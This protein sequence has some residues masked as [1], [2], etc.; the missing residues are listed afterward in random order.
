MSELRSSNNGSMTVP[1][2]SILHRL[3]RAAPDAGTPGR[4][5]PFL[6]LLIVGVAIWITVSILPEG[7]ERALRDALPFAA[8]S[9]IGFWRGREAPVFAFDGALFPEQCGKASI[10]DTRTVLLDIYADGG[11]PTALVG[12]PVLRLYR[13]S[14]QLLWA[15]I[16]EVERESLGVRSRLLVD[17]LGTSLAGTLRT[18]YF[19]REYRGEVTEILRSALR[20]AWAA[21]AV[22]AA[23]GE[24]M[25]SVDPQIVDGL[26]DGILPVA[27]EKAERTLWE[28]LRSMTGALFSQ[29]SDTTEGSP[30]ARAVRAIFEDERVQAHLLKTLPE[31]ASD[32]AISILATRITSEI[33]LA[34]INDARVPVLMTTLLTDPQMIRPELGAGVDGKFLTHEIPRWLLRYRHPNDHNPMVAFVVR[35]LLRGDGGHVGVLL[36]QAQAALVDA[37]GLRGGIALAEVGR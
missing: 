22:K 5:L 25:R 14:P 6:S 8:D 23:L 16:P 35:S 28:T 12:S 26:V 17:S 3:R 18:A 32:P 21:P 29:D 11:C 36:T 4:V 31:L 27:I 34:L 10:V 9:D 19:E 20:R 24:A 2:S 37:Q 1:A 30:M 33:G 13:A 15:M 7:R